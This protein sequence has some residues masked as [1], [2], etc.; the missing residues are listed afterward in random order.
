MSR[1]LAEERKGEGRMMAFL[2]SLCGSL[3]VMM[4]HAR[5]PSPPKYVEMYM[6][7]AVDHFNYELQDTFMERYFLSSKVND[8]SRAS[9]LVQF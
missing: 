8:R 7:Q 9:Y 4:A 1:G 6:E 3:M 5:A 2:L